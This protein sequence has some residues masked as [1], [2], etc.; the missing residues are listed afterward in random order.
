MRLLP[1]INKELRNEFS[2]NYQGTNQILRLNLMLYFYKNFSHKNYYQYLE[3][4]KETEYFFQILSAWSNM[5]NLSSLFLALKAVVCIHL[6][7][8]IFL[9]FFLYLCNNFFSFRKNFFTNTLKYFCMQPT[10]KFRH[11][12]FYILQKNLLPTSFLRMVFEAI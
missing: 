6:I 9:N 1:S 2:K 7:T 4:E 3:R 8:N 10:S 12:Q 11:I 5:L